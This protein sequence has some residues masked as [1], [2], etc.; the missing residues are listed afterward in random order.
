MDPTTQEEIV[1]GYAGI[2]KARWK[3][4]CQLC[5]EPHGTKGES[6]LSRDPP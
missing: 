6:A 1:R 3:L 5:S 2:E 4:K